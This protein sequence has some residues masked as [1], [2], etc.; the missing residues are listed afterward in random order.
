MFLRGWR[1]RKFLGE[2]EKYCYGGGGE[3]SCGKGEG[4]AVYF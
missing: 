3:G 4:G 2:G 1:T